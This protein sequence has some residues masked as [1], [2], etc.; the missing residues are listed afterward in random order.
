MQVGFNRMEGRWPSEDDCPGFRSCAERFMKECH[1]L[2]MQLL[3]CF[4]EGLGFDSDY[5]SQVSRAAQAP[6]VT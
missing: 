5:F 2:S 4:A 6:D 3:S 1:D